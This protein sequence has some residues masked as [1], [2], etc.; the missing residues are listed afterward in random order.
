M[1]RLLLPFLFVP[2]L[3]NAQSARNGPRLGAGLATITAGQ[4]LQWNGL[5]KVGPL[6][7]WSFEI[8]WTE[9]ASFL[10]EPMYITKGSLVQNPVLKSWTSNRLGYL[11]LPVMV[12]LSLQKD[13]GGIFLSGGFIG[14]LWINGRYKE[15]LNGTV[16]R[17]QKYTVSGSGNRTQVS[18]AAGLGWDLG[19]SAFEIRVQQSITPFSPIIRGQHLVVGLHY[20]FYIPK[21]DRSKKKTE[22]VED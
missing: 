20:T 11:E 1:R 2:F 5:P 8:P 3:L 10:F 22:E 19:A 21:K 14:G 13:P 18:I 4:F 9:Q 15:R 12:K 16:I 7:G 6:G 17:D